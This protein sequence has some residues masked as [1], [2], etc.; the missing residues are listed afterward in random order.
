MLRKYFYSL[1][2]FAGGLVIIMDCYA[3]NNDLRFKNL[4]LED[5]LSQSIV[6]S[7]IR[8]HDGFMWFGTYYGLNKYDGHKFEVY[9]NIPHDTTSLSDNDV[10]C[11][12]EDKNKR[13][14]IGTFGLGLN[15]FDREKEVFYHYLHDPDD[16]NTLSSN[17][18]NTLFEDKEGFIWIGTTDGL[19]KMDPDTRKIQRI[20]HIDGNENTL[21]DNNIQVI[22]QDQ[23]N[24]IWF[25]TWNGL[26]RFNPETGKFKNFR[27]IPGEE[28]SISDNTILALYEDKF[29]TI[30]VGTRFGGLNK[31]EK[32]TE[33]FKTYTRSLIGKKGL[34]HYTILSIIGDS[35]GQLWIGTWKGGLNIFNTKDETFKVYHHDASDE[36]SI[37]SDQIWNLYDDG[38]GI[39]WIGTHGGGISKLEYSRNFFEHFLHSADRPGSLSD[40]NVQS[41]FRDS[42][43]TLYVGTYTGGL[44][45][46]HYK[47]QT[48]STLSYNHNDPISSV[49][50]N[51]I[52][53]IVED[54]K[55]NLW[56]GTHITEN[57]GGLT[58]YNPRNN[59]FKHFHNN[60]G[61][62]NSLSNDDIRALFIDPEGNIWIGTEMG[63]LN[64]YIPS[65]NR[66]VRYRHKPE[67]IETLSSDRITQVTQDKEGFIWVG[68]RD[69]GL[70]KLNPVTG[71]VERYYFENNN[72][73]SLSNNHITKLFFSSDSILW[74]GTQYGLNRYNI[75][76][77]EFNHYYQKDGLPEDAIR[78]IEKDNRGNLWI[79]TAN[80]L[81]CFNPVNNSVTSFYSEDGLQSN[82]FNGSVS[83]GD[84][85]GKLYFGGVNGFNAFYPDSIRK[86]PYKPEIQITD[87]KIFNK[88]VECCIPGSVLSKSI[89]EMEEIVLTYRQNFISFEF[90]AL[91]YLSPEKNQYAYILEGYEEKW[92]EIGNNR[93]ANYTKLEPGEYVFRV[94]ASNNDKVW[95]TKGASIKVTIIPPF[96][97]TLWF[98][99]LAI[100]SLLGLALFLHRLRVRS[101]KLRKKVLEKLVKMRTLEVENQKKELENKNIRL[102]DQANELKEMNLQLDSQK[103]EIKQQADQIKGMNEILKQKNIKLTHDIHDISEARILQKQVTFKEF[104]EIY[105]D[106]ESCLRFLDDLKWKHGYRCMKCGS[107]EFRYTQ[108]KV[109]NIPFSRRCKKCKHIESPT[110]GTIFYRIKFPLVKAFY[111]VFLVMSG[112]DYTVNELSEK[113]H[114]RRQ[115]CWTFRKK[116]LDILNQSK[117]L[118]KNKDGWSHIVLDAERREIAQEVNII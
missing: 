8:D 84:R 27:K 58:W 63:G 33:S 61:N 21:C 103:E 108:L 80:G 112:K 36:S 79:S 107:K 99:G 91:N 100:L 74:I 9:R 114:L 15:L 94:K 46:F 44:N 14:W 18:I 111:I 48:F 68:T 118:K 53:C 117:N 82:E 17:K 105:P 26:S 51:R 106:D 57:T 19:N 31:Y 47:D 69:D 87:F 41:I 45:R 98:K 43:G 52:G 5:G 13:L 55:G 85:N 28:N 29:G 34:S 50:S 4:S 75:Y 95:N 92:N 2:L 83:F 12:L 42:R 56:I 1:I 113:L 49:S 110:V 64:K 70:N 60:P 40:N 20:Y 11:I 104:R 72:T 23:A 10:R 76:K 90:V 116:I 81:C 30:W 115:T 66:F 109:K 62:M 6:Y 78:S 88:P 96:Y 67:D 97:K 7:I 37:A 39:L 101:I 38:R 25:G 73:N 71:K 24:F 16:E 54:E 77:N 86:N 65:E 3:Q 93:V 59:T 22:M 35:T 89:T 102:T 32:E